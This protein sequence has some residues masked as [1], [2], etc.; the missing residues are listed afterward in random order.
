VLVEF[1]SIVVVVVYGGVPL[2]RSQVTEHAYPLSQCVT[3]RRSPAYPSIPNLL[4]RR[5]SR[6]LIG[7]LA[8]YVSEA[9]RRHRTFRI[10][11]LNSVTCQGRFGASNTFASALWIVD[12]LFQGAA[13]GIDGVNIH[14]WPQANPN[15]PF[16]FARTSG[17]EWRAFVRPSYYGVL[18]FNRAAPPGSRLLRTREAGSGDVRSWAALAP[19]RIA[20]VVLINA[21]QRGAHAALVHMP[22]SAGPATLD[23]LSAPHADSTGGVSIAGQTYADATTTQRAAQ[24]AG[25]RAAHAV[26]GGT[27]A[28]QRGAAECAARAVNSARARRMTQIALEVDEL[29]VEV[30]RAMRKNVAVDHHWLERSER[31]HGLIEILPVQAHQ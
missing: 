22:R 21:S 11:E 30:V 9:H 15:E 24:T 6:G 5:S 8:P 20:N 16:T 1:Q 26:S 27:T 12:T 23:R 31:A 17:G 25:T 14:M 3:D 13:V 18:M 28:G 19:G 29:D 10:D 2:T 4:A 7:R